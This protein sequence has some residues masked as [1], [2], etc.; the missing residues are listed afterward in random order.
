MVYE[1]RTKIKDL[2]A[3]FSIVEKI[4]AEHYFL[5]KDVICLGV[6]SL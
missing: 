1:I 5:T 2:R 3:A 6:L 4:F